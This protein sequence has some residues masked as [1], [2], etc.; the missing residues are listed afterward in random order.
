MEDVNYIDFENFKN[1][2]DVYYFLFF[3]SQS[4]KL[5]NY[6]FADEKDNSFFYEYEVVYKNEKYRMVHK[7]FYNK[8]NIN[9]FF[10]VL[11]IS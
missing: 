6:K 5:L 2:M 9:D 3:N 11:K 1:D 7:G 8:N 4:K 10:D